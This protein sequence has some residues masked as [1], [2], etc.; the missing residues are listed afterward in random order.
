MFR[1]GLDEGHERSY[2]L[3]VQVSV[4]S[5][6]FPDFSGTVEDRKLCFVLLGFNKRLGVSLNK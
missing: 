1:V 6:E 5:S 2:S 3:L 4:V